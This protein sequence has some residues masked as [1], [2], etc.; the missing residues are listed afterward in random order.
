[1]KKIGVVSKIE[2]DEPYENNNL[3]TL[4]V[5]DLFITIYDEHKEILKQIKIAIE[6]TDYTNKNKNLLY[7]GDIVEF[8]TES[9]SVTPLVN[10]TEENLKEINL[11]RT[12]YENQI[13]IL[14]EKDISSAL[15][16][17]S[18]VYEARQIAHF[19]KNT[20]KCEQNMYKVRIRNIL[21]EINKNPKL[22]QMMYK[23][24]IENSLSNENLME[25]LI[26]LGT[27][28]KLYYDNLNM[29]EVET[30]GYDDNLNRL[31]NSYW[32]YKYYEAIAKSRKMDK[33]SNLV[34]LEEVKEFL[35]EKQK[36]PIKIKKIGN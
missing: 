20:T 2:Y 11:I 35:T 32:L 25:L 4:Y 8:D 36:L 21:S 22:T 9:C 27:D 23:K 3:E 17:C 31:L 30:D 14:E 10:F 33:I 15:N 6:T 26:R 13:R 12:K 18:N 16:K 28:M 29:F 19:L 1:M 5:S 34:D 7:L 24:P